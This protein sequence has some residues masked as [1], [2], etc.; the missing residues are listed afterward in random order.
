MQR[1]Q[2]EVAQPPTITLRSYKVRAQGRCPPIINLLII[3]SSL[4]LFA[5]VN[6]YFVVEIADVINGSVFDKTT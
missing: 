3:G 6:T 5:Y 2:F 1:E 4:G